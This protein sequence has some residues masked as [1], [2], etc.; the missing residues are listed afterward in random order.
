MKQASLLITQCLQNDF[1][2]LLE[3]YEPL[4]NALHVG[5]EEAKRLLGEDVEDSPVNRVMEWAYNTPTE[6]LKIVHIRDWHEPGKIQQ[7]AHLKQFGKHC[8][9]DTPGASFVF[10]DTMRVEREDFIVDA[11]GLNDFAE[12]D[13]AQVLQPHLQGEVKIG[14]IG[15][16]TEAKVSF[17][18]YDLKTR[19]P[20]TQIAVCSALTASSSRSMHFIALE[21]LQDILGI[22]V[23]PSIADFTNF[24]TGTT[25]QIEHR[26]NSRI[27]ASHLAFEPETYQISP[28]DEKILLY[29][30]RDAKN[31]AFSS[32]DGGFSGNVVLKAEPTDVYGHKQA[33]S[34]IKIG[35]REMIAKERTSFERIQHV[36]GNNAPS[37]VDFVELED[38][39]AIKYRYA[40]MFDNN[41]KTFQKLYE[42]TNDLDE[43]ERIL[44]IVF[45]KQ[46]GR[47]YAAALPEVLNL[48]EYY[49]FSDR[50]AASVRRNVEGIIGKEAV[51]D[52]L[53]ILGHTFPNVCLFYEK[54]LKTLKEDVP[55]PHSVSYI[56]GDLNGANII[57]DGQQNVWLIDFFHTHRGHILKDLI[58]FENDLLFIFTK[59][60]SEAEFHEGIRLIDSLLQV[61][62]LGVAFTP[63]PINTF[64]FP[65]F[66]KAAHSIKILRSFY[67]DLIKMDRSPYQYFIAFMRY[68]MHTTSFEECNDWQK[69]LALYAGSQ[70]SQKIKNYLNHSKDLRIDSLVVDEIYDK[71]IGMTI[72]PG[73]KD[74]E[75]DLTTDIKTIQESGIHSILTLLS[76]DEFEQYGVDNL[77]E[78]YKAAGLESKHV[79]IIDQGIPSIPELQKVLHWMH[80]KI[81]NKQAILVHCVGGLGRT[82]TIIA[83]YL[84]WYHGYS[85]EDAIAAVRKSRSQRAVESKLQIEFLQELPSHKKSI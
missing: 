49:E 68:A 84:I 34:V 42:T 1:V 45:D 70:A 16:W 29:L 14:I 78:A 75:R 51:G 21:Q 65:Q 22:Q 10:Q 11:T 73:R 57:I 23:Y 9:K 77:L 8:I 56:H 69:K 46:L 48:L 5:Y 6:E 7:E 61:S 82:G 83:A 4:P 20:N 18:C 28:V 41:V 80:E 50:Y 44:R 26:L 74:R 36:L 35:Q 19:Y 59:V 55:A 40:A 52:T 17:L 58:K 27:N 15:V 72:L 54:D 47:M 39:G 85:A 38:R 2:K 62:D 37:I 32:L 53:E 60:H 67:P 66:Q 24:L 71:G 3:R 81:E 63:N 25:P 30:F 33:P 43:I 76:S 13:L 31:V 12:T 79:S 64:Q